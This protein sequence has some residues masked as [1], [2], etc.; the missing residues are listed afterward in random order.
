DLAFS[1]EDFQDSIVYDIFAVIGD[2]A[3]VDITL[4][5]WQGY[6]YVVGDANASGGYNGLDITYGVAYFKGGNPPPYQCDCPPHGTWYVAGD[7]NA[8]CDYNGLDITYGVSY[9]KGIIP[10]RFPCPDCPPGG[11]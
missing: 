6:E 7:V 1:H 10:E 11:P 5:A 3:I 2:T 9:L 4:R 8:S